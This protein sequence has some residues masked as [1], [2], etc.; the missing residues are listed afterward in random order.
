MKAFVP[1]QQN[2][3]LSPAHL[4]NLCSALDSDD[5]EDDEFPPTKRKHVVMED[6]FAAGVQELRQKR[7][8][9]IGGDER[10]H[11]CKEVEFLTYPRRPPSKDGH[12]KATK[13]SPTNFLQ[14]GQELTSDD[15]EEEDDPPPQRMNM[16]RED[17]FEAG[18]QELRAKCPGLF[19]ADSSRRLRKPERLSTWP[20]QSPVA[21]PKPKRSCSHAP[22]NLRLLDQT[23]SPSLEA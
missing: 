12:M 8:D 4:L 3:Q 20:R 7:P 9:L 21:A 6:E 2:M 19:K 13:M 16:L 1:E 14:L 5:S 17:D 23:R 15:S 10:R 18:V 11:L 22:C